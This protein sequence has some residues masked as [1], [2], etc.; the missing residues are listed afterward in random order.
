MSS[1]NESVQYFGGTQE[2]LR[3]QL[4]GKVFPVGTSLHIN[5]TDTDRKKIFVITNLEPFSYDNTP[6]SETVQSTTTDDTRVLHD[7]IDKL[8]ERITKLEG[9]LSMTTTRMHFDK[10]GNLVTETNPG[11][12]F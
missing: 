2:E 3:E 4:D 1:Y 10:D 6:Y 12:V 9:I 5:E 8:E 7:R 11:F